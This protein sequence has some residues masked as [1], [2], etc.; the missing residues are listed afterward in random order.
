MRFAETSLARPLAAPTPRD[1][2]AIGFRQKRIVLVSFFLVLMGMALSWFFTPRYRA[3]MKILVRRERLEP[4]VSSELNVAQAKTEE[5]SEEELNSEVELLNSQELLRK[6]V[7]ATGLQNPNPVAAGRSIGTSSEIDIA[8]A[9]ERLRSRLT[10][11]PLHKTNIIS[12]AFDAADPELAARVL[13]NLAG[14]YIEKHL[15]VHRPTGEFKFF[16]QQTERYRNGLMEA[17]AHLDEF[18]RGHGVVAPDLERDLAVQKMAEFKGS[19]EQTQTQIAEDQER[20]RIL[21]EQEASLPPRQLAQVRTSDN[22]QLMQ[23]MKSTLLTLGLKRTELM[24]KYDPAYRPVQEV[25]KQIAD[26]Q[27]AIAKEESTPIREETNSQNPAHE[28]VAVELAKA[29]TDLVGLQ[30]KATAD[31]TALGKYRASASNLQEA[32]IARQDLLRTAKT[33]EDNYLLYLHKSE[34]ARISDALDQRGFLNVAIA[35]QP[36]VPALPVRSPLLFGLLGIFLAGTGSLGLAMISDFFSPSFRTP[37][38]V[39]AYLGAPVLASIPEGALLRS[40]A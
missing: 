40:Q 36:M 27:A 37:S 28:W 25:D 39:T 7:L 20:I 23:E 15:E 24:S 16:D 3:H 34:Q 21:K 30:A 13:K 8:R 38:E 14:F 11:E 35:E 17:E 31:G 22:P 4:V 32:S 9:T 18:A 19:Y 2:F 6:V 10:I 12:V 29:Q 26:T 1:L 5:M 33:Q